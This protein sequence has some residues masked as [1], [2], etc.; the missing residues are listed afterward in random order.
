MNQDKL[1]EK[2]LSIKNVRTE[3]LYWKGKDTRKRVITSDNGEMYGVVGRNYHAVGHGDM[4]SRVMEWLPEGKIVSVATGGR[5]HTKAIM[6]IELP[7][8]FDVGGQAIK[9][10]VNLCNSLDGI[11]KQILTVTPVRICCT[12]Q[13]VLNKREAYISLEHKHTRPGVAKFNNEVRLVEQVYN[14]LSGQLYLAEK[15]IDLP[16]TT[17]K[18]IEFIT[19]LSKAKL[20][21]AKIEEK[22]IALYD[23]PIRPE[24]EGR[25]HWTLFNAI[26]DPINRELQSE[27][28]TQSFLNIENIGDIFTELAVV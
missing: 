5:N 21:P 28:K 17:E 3:P 6:S 22:A 13:F 25:N 27:K 18:G 2:V 24:D 26:T 19:N 1:I 15:L 8:I 4:Y 14:L 20:I 23:T 16:C 11:W 7:K 12:N 9:V 10:Y